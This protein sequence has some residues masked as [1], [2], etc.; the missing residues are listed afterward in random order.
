MTRKNFAD[1]AIHTAFNPIYAL[2]GR[3]IAV[4]LLSSFLDSVQQVT[5]PQDILLRQFSEQQRLQTLQKQIVIIERY[6][7]FLQRNSIAVLLHL[8]GYLAR[9]ILSSDFLRRK[10]RSLPA[11]ELALSESFPDFKAGRDNPELRAL[12]AD[13]KLTLNNFGS[14]KAP[15]KAVY[16]NLFT[17]IKLDRG[18]LQQLLQR[19]SFPSLLKTLIEQLSDHCRQ[20]IAQGV[21]SVDMLEKIS[22]FAFS[23]LQ[24]TLFPPAPERQL[25]TLTEPPGVFF[26][27]RC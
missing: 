12:S 19:D 5:V 13:F 11:L 6:H 1:Y 14:G 17:R 9:L 18:L 16:D 8:D 15:A 2:N 22:S 3:L 20:F 23:G 25:M 26:G 24:G 7:D 10:L 21:D 4:E 27:G